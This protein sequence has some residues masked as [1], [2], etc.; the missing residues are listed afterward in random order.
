VHPLLTTLG[1][2]LA[3][4]W[5]NLLVLPGALFLGVAAAGTTLGH[6]RWHDTDRLRTALDGLAA[7]P[8]AE[9]PGTAALLVAAALLLATAA[10]LAAQSLGGA[11]ERYWLRSS[12]DP[13]SHALVERRRRRW[14]RGEQRR[15]DAIRRHAEAALLRPRRSDDDPA[16]PPDDD[17]EL[18]L[19]PADLADIHALTLARDR[20]APVRPTR[21]TWYGDR[22]EAAAERVHDAYGVDLAALWPRLWLVLAEP[23]QR[24]IQSARDSF[25]VAGRL[26]AWAVGYGVLA[27]WWWPAALIAVGCAVTARTRARDAVESLAELMEAAVDVHGRELAALVGL[28]AADASGRLER[29]TGDRLSEL[30]RK[31]G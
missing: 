9:R 8:A 7:R 20:I 30:F 3:E 12:G 21:P 29:D 18:L 23:A 19:P 2:R 6:A 16:A 25:S 4:R 11:V 27:L 5:L 24:Q 28:I 10:S 1:G 15:L 14:D 31:G 17:G 26:A 22:M 13:V